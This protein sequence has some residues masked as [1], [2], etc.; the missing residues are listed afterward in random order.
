MEAKFFEIKN[1]IVIEKF[2]NTSDYINLKIDFSKNY[3]YNVGKISCYINHYLKNLRDN[4]KEILIDNISYK[5]DIE[6]CNDCFNKVNS[7][8]SDLYTDFYIDDS[9]DGECNNYVL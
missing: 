9:E 4:N 3:I 1:E 8:A 2:K 5:Y 7:I 6:N